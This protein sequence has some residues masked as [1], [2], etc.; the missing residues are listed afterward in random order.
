MAFM[1]IDLLLEPAST[2]HCQELDIEIALSHFLQLV[3]E[4]GGLCGG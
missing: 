4:G 2:G 3:S 1:V